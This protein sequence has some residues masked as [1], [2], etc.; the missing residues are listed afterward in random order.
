M[1]SGRETH[2]WS[3]EVNP[4][5]QLP[6]LFLVFRLSAVVT[7]RWEPEEQECHLPLVFAPLTGTSFKH[8]FL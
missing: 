7:M 5:S 2:S 6:C 8:T 4:H 3:A 1:Q